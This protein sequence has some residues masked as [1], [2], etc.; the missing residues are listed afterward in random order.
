M[1]R[2]KGRRTAVVAGMRCAGALAVF[3]CGWI[4]SGCGTPAQPL[5]PTLKLPELVK[6]LSARRVGD[7][8]HLKWTTSRRSTD[9]VVIQ[10]KVSFYIWRKP[11]TGKGDR[12]GDS[13]AEAGEEAEFAD[14]LPS[15]LQKGAPSLITYTVEL[16]NHQG[17]SAGLSNLAYSAAGAAPPAVLDLSAT[18]TK[19]GVLLHWAALENYGGPETFRIHRTMLDADSAKKASSAGTG[20]VPASMT[21]LVTP[22]E[23]KDRGMALD[24]SAT[25]G[26]RYE[27]WI[28]RLIHD[29]VGGKPVEIVSGPSNLIRVNAKD[30]FPP[31]PPEALVAVAV[32]EQGTIDLSWSPNTEADLAGYVVYRAEAGGNAERISPANAPVIAP[33]YR[34]ATAQAGHTYRY[35]VSA[36]DTSGNE[37]ARSAEATETLPAAGTN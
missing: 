13:S 34:D 7:T 27:Y 26:H 25:F 20:E 12:V 32:A 2:P 29:E 24:A 15:E 37:S 1:I 28:E 22:K 11:G 33:T 35:W 31:L 8:V 6:D 19:E 10:G 4:V 23:G 30:V 21:L 5:P 18:V 17:H 16:L 3:L 36:V 14:Q 9:N